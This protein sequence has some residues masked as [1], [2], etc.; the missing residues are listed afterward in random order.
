VERTAEDTAVAH[1]LD[2][3]SFSLIDEPAA[4]LLEPTGSERP[5]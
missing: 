4:L 5:R 3:V 2:G 1:V